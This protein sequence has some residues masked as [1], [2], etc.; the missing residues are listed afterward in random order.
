MQMKGSNAD[1]LFDWSD[2]RLLPAF[3]RPE[4]LMVYDVLHAPR[5]VQ[6][7]LA[8]FVGLLNRPQPRIYLLGRDNDLFWLNEAL[9]SIPHTLSPLANTEIVHELL[10]RYRTAVR[11]MIIY[12]PALPD[13]VNVATMMSGLM[14]GIIVSPAQ[15]ESFQRAPS[16]YKLPVLDD[17]RKYRWRSRVQIYQWAY[18]NFLPYC[19]TRMVAGM[20]PAIA[21]GIR[22]FLV[23]TRTFIYWL[24]PLGFLPRSTPSW[25]S[26]YGMMSRILRAYR[27]RAVHLGWFVQEGSGV[28]MTSQAAIPVACTDY[29]SNLE[30]WS[31]VQPDP[32]Q[33]EPVYQSEFITPKAEKKVYLS[34]TF[35]EGD[36][37]QYV[38]GRMLDIWRQP[39]RGL[40]PLGWPMS[41][42]MMQAAP[43]MLAYYQRT[44]SP[45]DEFI[46]APSGVAYSYPSKWP[47]EELDLYLR[48]T[49]KLMQQMNM[50]ALAVLDSNYWLH[51]IL[52]Y[53]AFTTGSGLL[54]RE[55]A[56]QRQFA[57]TLQQ[58]GVRGVL[59]GG[60]LT[61]VSWRHHAGVP[62]YHNL[63]T[64]R[65]AAEAV[66]MIKRATPA[67]RPHFINLYVLAWQIGPTQLQQV[68]AQLGSE[69]EIVTPGTLLA[70]LPDMRK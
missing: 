11:G 31:T 4:H 7:S 35:S 13:T 55:Q 45:N 66:R 22:S 14:D 24:N 68:V 44:A 15:A 8:S 57:H 42:V 16:P 10:M 29:F 59:S 12:D 1:D 2:G 38:Q 43:E 18:E 32:L 33:S 65:D 56:L 48:H 23:A 61:H 6:L 63:G 5:D 62:I 17:L 53:R 70:M 69:Y 47:Y 49:G 36:N 20:D 64:A 52:I 67:T 40:L 51:P 54:L 26:E 28:T 41:L 3:Q 30:V 46:A 58:F 21:L 60:G 19:S 27:G 37:L 9:P 25:R 50:Q 39:E 34:F